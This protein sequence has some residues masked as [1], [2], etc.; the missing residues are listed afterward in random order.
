MKTQVTF[1]ILN[2]KYDQKYAKEYHFGKESGNNLKYIWSEG[3]ELD[4]VEL[5]SLIENEPYI[6]K[7][8]LETGMEFKAEFSKVVIFRCHLDNGSYE[9]FAVSKSILNKTHQAKKAGYDITRFYFYINSEPASLQLGSNLVV[10]EKEIPKELLKP[11]V[12]N[13]ENE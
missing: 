6:L 5:V 8:R 1:K 13:E 10:D 11:I 3:Y 4:N 12:T 7:G 9:D 2:P